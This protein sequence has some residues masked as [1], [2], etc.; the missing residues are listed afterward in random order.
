MQAVSI[1]QLQYIGGNINVVNDSEVK[2]IIKREFLSRAIQ[3]KQS[4]ITGKKIFQFM[5]LCLVYCIVHTYT[6]HI[7]INIIIVFNS[8][9]VSIDYHSSHND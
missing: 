1:P 7:I 3:V 2:S 5:C 8:V 9:I 4:S 6:S